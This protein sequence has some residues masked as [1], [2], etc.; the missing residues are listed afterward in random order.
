MS[1][2]MDKISN[3][4]RYGKTQEGDSRTVSN[5]LHGFQKIYQK[6]TFERNQFRKMRDSQRLGHVGD[7]R[8]HEFSLIP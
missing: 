7:P 1:I 5:A 3:R 2:G 6:M 8:M 4:G